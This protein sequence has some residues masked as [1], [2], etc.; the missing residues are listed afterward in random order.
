MDI[1]E[2]ICGNYEKHTAENLYAGG[3]QTETL[4]VMISHASGRPTWDAAVTDIR[5]AFLL[6]P[7]STD[8]F[9]GLRFPKVFLLALG[10]EWDWLYRVDKA[11]YGFRRSPR[12]WGLFRDARFRDAQLRIGNNAAVLKRLTADENVWKVVKVPQTSQNQEK[13]IAYIIVY[14]DDIMYLGPPSVISAVHKWLSSDWTASS[15]TWASSSGGIRFLE[16]EVYKRRSG[17]LMCQL[18]YLTEL[19]RHHELNNGPGARTPC[20]R[21]WLLGEVTTEQA[22]FEELSL[23]RAQ[24]LTGELLWLS[25]KLRPD[26]MHAVASI[27][28]LCLRDPILVERIGLR[29]LA[30]L[31]STLQVDLMF[32]CDN[33]A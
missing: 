15:L 31:Y 14:V 26:I 30:Y 24:R 9:Y 6:A 19:L 18:G 21:E 13:T 12:L 3:C 5:N 1:R 4:R 22:V 11:L 27:S 32:T 8:A 16:L 28:S 17:Y 23:R 2:S 33:K 7:M 10:P 20:P 29:A 25:T